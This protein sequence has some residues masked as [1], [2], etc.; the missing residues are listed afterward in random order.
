M[1]AT[2]TKLIL[3]DCGECTNPAEVWQNDPRPLCDYCA[4]AA[5]C[6]PPKKMRFYSARLTG[7]FRA[8]CKMCDFVSAYFECGCDLRHDC[9][10]KK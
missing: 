7:E 5:E 1:I 8:E 10:G 2:E 9:E 3:T 4:H 6:R